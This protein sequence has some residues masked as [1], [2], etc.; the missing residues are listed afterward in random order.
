LSHRKH[1][2]LVRIRSADAT[3][4]RAPGS[5]LG[6]VVLRTGSQT[7]P[8]VGTFALTASRTTHAAEPILKN[9]TFPLSL[10]G[11]HELFLTFSANNL[12]L[13]NWVQFE[14]EGITVVKA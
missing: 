7:G 9:M 11:Q 10:E 5:A 2:T 6:N 12:M 14:G 13:L 1:A 8:V 4:G 3:A